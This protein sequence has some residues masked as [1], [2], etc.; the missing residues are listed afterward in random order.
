MY[1]AMACMVQWHVWCNGM[2]GWCIKRYVVVP[3]TMACMVQ[4]HA[5]LAFD[6]VF[7]SILPGI[8]TDLH[9][10]VCLLS[11]V[12]VRL[13]ARVGRRAVVRKSQNTLTRA[14]APY[15]LYGVKYIDLVPLT[16]CTGDSDRQEGGL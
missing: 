4:W 12:G 5:W 1:G 15:V 2:Y 8:I 16:L 10:N 14:V 6:C 9:L 13:Q 3:G 7:Y 11:Q